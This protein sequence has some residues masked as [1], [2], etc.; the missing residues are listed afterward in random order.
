MTQHL[1]KNNDIGTVLIVEDSRAMRS[2]LTAYLDDAHGIKTVETASFA[3]ALAEL[4]DHAS[5]FFAAVLDLHLPDAPN[6]E[7]VDLVCRYGIPVVVLTGSLDFA[8]RE[9]MLARQVVD[10][11]IKHNRNEIEQVAQTI[12]RLWH[13]REIKVLVVDDSRSFRTYLH[14]L[15]E[16]YRYQTFTASN[17]REALAML[18][19]HPNISLVITDIN[20]PEMNGLELIEAI[21]QRYRREDLAIIGMSDASRPSLPALLLKTGANDFIAKPF[22]SEEFFCRVSQNTNMIDYVRRLRDAAT[23][24]FLTGISNRRHA[25][26]LSEA[27]HA[28]AQRGHFRIA[29]G[30]IDV[31]HFKR[32]N[33]TFG[34]LVGDEALKAIAN[35]LRKTLRSSDIVGRYGGEEFFCVVVLKQEDDAK[36]VFDRVRSAIERIEFHVETQRVPLTASV[37]FTTDLDGSLIQMIARADTAVYQ[38]KEQGRN[39]VVRY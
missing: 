19:M 24:D 39:R 37:G 20:M 11:F 14:S 36:L 3:E 1:D 4:A 22:Q 8:R 6:G 17:G 33:D 16:S 30:M 31:D 38:A 32:V 23:R 13:N 7:I 15:L 21:R 28:N 35:A 27:L 26:E 10:Y 9:T 34:H 29:L 12:N 2:L 25:L 5:R 18:D